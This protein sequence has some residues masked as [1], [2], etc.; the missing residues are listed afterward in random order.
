MRLCSKLKCALPIMLAS[1]AIAGSLQARSG[2]PSAS[3]KEEAAAAEACPA[4]YPHGRMPFTGLNPAIEGKRKLSNFAP[5]QIVEIDFTTMEDTTAYIKELRKI[6]VHVSIYLPGGHCNI[7]NKD[8][9]NLEKAGVRRLDTTGSWNWD[10]DERRIVDITHPASLERLKEGAKRGWTLGANYIRVDNL[11]YP[12][13]SKEPR[14]AKQAKEIFEA[15][16]EVEDQLRAEKVIP[17]DRPTGLVAHNNL[18][19]WEELIRTKAIRRPPVFLTSERT[20]QLAYK[21]EK[22]KGDA[23]LKAGR[24]QPADNAEIMAGSRIALALG[25]PYSVAE[26]RISHDLGGVRGSTY[27]LPQYYVDAVAKI[28]GV[29]DLFVI[30]TET[31]YVG[32][33][34]PYPGPGPRHLPAGPLPKN[35]AE[36]AAKCLAAGG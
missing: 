12:A 34:R 2:Q 7:E 5:N 8:C 36:I 35:A 22:F 16:L 26:F 20:A 31:S 1:L 23:E 11:H 4:L 24:L 17:A 32:R 33:G 27:K 6:P 28:P 29:S 14:T 25:I 3:T 19:V 15:L 13:G 10:K 18:D 21:G 9:A 30:P